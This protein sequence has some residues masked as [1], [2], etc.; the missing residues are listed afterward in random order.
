MYQRYP[1]QNSLQH[2]EFVRNFVND[3]AS[4]LMGFGNKRGYNLSE[5]FYKD[6]SW[7]G[8]HYEDSNGVYKLTPW[9]TKEESNASVR[10]RI[11]NNINIEQTGRDQNGNQSVQKGSNSGC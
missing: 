6:L 9:F 10:N 8:T 4:A 7:G 2:A 3:I 11:L 5:Q 1:N